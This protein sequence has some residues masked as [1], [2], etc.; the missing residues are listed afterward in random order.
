ME[1]R[2]TE[3]KAPLVASGSLVKQSLASSISRSSKKGVVIMNE[4]EVPELLEKLSMS[5]EY[6]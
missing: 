4:E 6:R 3:K 2:P 5:G 1:E